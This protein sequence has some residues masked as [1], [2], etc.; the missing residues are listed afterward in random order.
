M[1]LRQHGMM[2]C[3]CNTCHLWDDILLTKPNATHRIFEVCQYVKKKAEGGKKIENQKMHKI[4]MLS[5]PDGLLHRD[6]QRHSRFPLR[7]LV[8]A[9][10]A[11]SLGISIAHV[12]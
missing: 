1:S 10:E 3:P 4:P 2:L 7:S 11:E 9:A 6:Q 12:I 8:H 5:S